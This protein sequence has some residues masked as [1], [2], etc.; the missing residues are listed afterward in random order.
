MSDI[1]NA[2]LIVGKSLI[3]NNKEVVKDLLIIRDNKL[4]ILNHICIRDPT[5]GVEKDSTTNYP[6]KVNST[7]IYPVYVHHLR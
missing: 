5:P 6:K 4:T 1:I 7:S 3:K 2:E